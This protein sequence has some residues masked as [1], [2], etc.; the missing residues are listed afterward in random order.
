MPI[1]E[2]V[3]AASGTKRRISGNHSFAAA[4]SLRMKKAMLRLLSSSDKACRYRAEMVRKLDPERIVPR[5]DLPLGG[6]DLH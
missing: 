3:H 6:H 5:H 2:S 4:M 1:R